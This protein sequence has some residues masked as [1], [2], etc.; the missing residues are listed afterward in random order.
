LILVRVTRSPNSAA[1][2][3]TAGPATTAEPRITAETA[4]TGETKITAGKITAHG[5]NKM[6]P[7]VAGQPGSRLCS[8]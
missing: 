4:N 5:H 3:I 6:P 8:H 7:G 2:A 1:P